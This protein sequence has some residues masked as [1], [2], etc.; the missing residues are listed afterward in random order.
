MRKTMLVKGNTPEE[1][2]QAYN[3]A[4]C[5]CPGEVVDEKFISDTMM[6][7]NTVPVTDI[8][9]ATEAVTNRHAANRLQVASRMLSTSTVAFGPSARQY[10]PAVAVVTINSAAIHVIMARKKLKNTAV[11][12]TGMA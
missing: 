3:Q 5:S 8:A 11:R 6:L 1:F 7:V 12:L 4:Q 10:T 2:A 9:I